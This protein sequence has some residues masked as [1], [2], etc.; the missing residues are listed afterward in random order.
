MSTEIAEYHLA[1]H[2]ARGGRLRLRTQGA[3]R[4]Y[5][6]HL[7]AADFACVIAIL[8]RSPAFLTEG[9]IHTGS[10]PRLDLNTS[11]PT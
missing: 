8:S 1:W 9:W 4:W 5:E 10:D 11:V 6:F 3:A 2:P 7:G